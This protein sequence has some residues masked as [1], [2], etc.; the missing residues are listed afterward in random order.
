MLIDHIGF[1]V[2]DFDRSRAFYNRCLLPLGFEQIME[3]QGWVGYG[4]KDKAEFWFGPG[5]SAQRPMHIAFIAENREMVDRFYQAALAAGARDNGAPGV[6]EIYH[7]D[8]YGAFV[9]DPDGHNIEAVCHKPAGDRAVQI[10]SGYIPGLLGRV[11]EMHAS[12]YAQQWQ[13][14][15]NFETRVSAEMS[16]FFNRF[17]GD[18]DGCW[19]ALVD[20]KIEASITIDGIDAASKGAH[21]R[22][23]IASDAVRGKGV[24]RRLITLAMD[25]CRL[26]EYSLVYLDSFEG[27]EAARHLYE[28]AGFQLMQTVTGDQWGTRVEEQRF[29][30]RI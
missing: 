6:R 22:W 14:T 5:T 27:L 15:R 11:T 12:Y 30:A 13:F 10:E 17:D 18:R 8:Y 1:E 23:F 19:S 20:G 26:K 9:I 4:R 29:E 16:E 24:G 3:D 7:S 21:L 28:S 2:T 25:F